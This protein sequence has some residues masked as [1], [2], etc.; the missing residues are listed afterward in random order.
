MNA[1]I[2]YILAFL[3]GIGLSI[4]VGLN[5]QLRTA[6]G[7]PI[8][9]SIIAFVVGTLVLILYAL[10]FDRGSFSS[11]SNLGTVSWY[12]CLGGFMGA[13]Y[14]AGIILLAPR[15]GITSITA[16]VVAGQLV[17]ALVLD[18]YGLF[19]FA[20]Q[21]INSLK[22]VGVCLLMAGVMLIIRN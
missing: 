20:Q 15:I 16:L 5:T 9:A 19:D 21:P 13:F 17:L 1:S 2:Y 10:F 4:Q 11:L 12:K 6:L 14:I 18:H 7:S 22:I 3:I 8:M